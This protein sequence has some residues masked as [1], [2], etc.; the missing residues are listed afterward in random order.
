VS[1]E[2]ERSMHPIDQVWKALHDGKWLVSESK[3]G[4][5]KLWYDEA[6]DAYYLH[7]TTPSHGGT[8][9]EPLQCGRL[10]EATALFVLLSSTANYPK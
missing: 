3:E 9:T 6:T 2:Q 8:S 1:N 5:V 4:V 7:K 10:P